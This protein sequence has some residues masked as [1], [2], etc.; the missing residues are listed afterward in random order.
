ME[1]KY[2]ITSEN[3]EDIPRCGVRVGMVFDQKINEL[4]KFPQKGRYSPD[5]PP[6]KIP[7]S[8]VHTNVCSKRFPAHYTTCIE[9][10][11]PLSAYNI[12]TRLDD[13]NIALT[14]H[15]GKAEMIMW[16][17]TELEVNF[18]DNGMK[19]ILMFYMSGPVGKT[20]LVWDKYPKT[21]EMFFEDPSKTLL[22]KQPIDETKLEITPMK[23]NE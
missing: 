1:Q 2:L 3:C 21:I 12:I 6:I 13:M 19:E 18:A 17:K 23:A 20:G 14:V 22:V 16:D 4:E 8:I 9:S 15:K 11:R 5:I 7:L 10:F